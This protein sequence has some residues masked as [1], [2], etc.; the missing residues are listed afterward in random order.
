MSEPVRV[1]ALAD[2]SE[3]PRTT[4]SVV[5]GLLVSGFTTESTKSFPWREAE[6]FKPQKL[7]DLPSRSYF[8]AGAEKTVRNDVPP[9]CAAYIS[10]TWPTGVTTK[11]SSWARYKELR[12]LISCA[13]LAIATWLA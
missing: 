2:L 4:I 7:A 12:Q 1:T 5:R 9:W 8:T 6:P 13:Q 10:K 11:R 3:P